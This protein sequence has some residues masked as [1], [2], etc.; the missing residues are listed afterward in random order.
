VQP[1]ARIDGR[2]PA[3]GK[4][5]KVN[6]IAVG[7]QIGGAELGIAFAENWSRNCRR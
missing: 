2:L 3:S 6:H 7:V 5:K 4:W 1:Q